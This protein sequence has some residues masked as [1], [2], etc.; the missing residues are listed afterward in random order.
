MA[1]ANRTQAA[2]PVNESVKPTE[3]DEV[4]E[5]VDTTEA[6]QSTDAPVA[7]VET[8]PAAP[9][10]TPVEPAKPTTAPV[11]KLVTDGDKIDIDTS[12]FGP[13][14]VNI[15]DSIR[16]YIK[17]MNN[18]I[19]ITPETGKRMQ[20]ALWYN[21]KRI[22]N[23]VDEIEFPG[24]MNAVLALINDNKLNRHGRPGA[25]HETSVFRFANL[26]NLEGDEVSQFKNII[27]TMVRTADAR[28][29]AMAVKQINWEAVTGS[30]LSDRARKRIIFFYNVD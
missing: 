24:V 22:F 14:A 15:I 8:P 13:A 7:P 3:V 10:E 18:E 19:M 6:A 25:F 2:Q 5:S 29:R 17:A 21:V 11:A 28:T 12:N 4:L 27:I 26:T 1:K 30:N 23:Q 20:E 16:D 9:V